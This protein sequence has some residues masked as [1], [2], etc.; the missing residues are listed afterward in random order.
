[1]KKIFFNNLPMQNIL[2]IKYK[3]IGISAIKSNKA[4][5]YS[6]NALLAGIMKKEDVKIVLLKTRGKNNICDEHERS[7]KEE[8]EA[9]NVSIKANIKYVVIETPYKE[10]KD[11]HEFLLGKIVDEID[12]DSQLYADITYG[13]KPLPIILFT[14][15]AFAQKFLAAEIKNIIYSKVDFIDGKASNGEI[16]DVSPLYYL[17]SLSNIIDRKDG[18]Y[19]RNLLKKLLN[20]SDEGMNGYDGKKNF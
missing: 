2:P 14:A 3:A 12:D 6:L 10:T 13:P 1:M 4:V 15:L 8:L 20:I 19:A 18:A 7:F 11:I 5:R 17:N 16:L 9:I